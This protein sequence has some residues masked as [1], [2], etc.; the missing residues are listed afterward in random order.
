M[1][2]LPAYKNVILGVIT[3][4]FPKME[5]IEEMKKRVYEAAKF[6]AQGSG[7]TEEDALN[8]LGVSPQCGMLC[9]AVA[10]GSFQ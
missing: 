8:R 2:E 1:K 10:C 3:S 4:K 9:F 6:V 7:E 5:D